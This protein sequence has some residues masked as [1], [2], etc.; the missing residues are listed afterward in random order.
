MPLHER[1]V[2]HW[3]LQL[4][5]HMRPRPKSDMNLYR[6]TCFRKSPM[7]S[8]V[9]FIF[10]FICFYAFYRGTC[11]FRDPCSAALTV[12]STLVS[13]SKIRGNYTQRGNF[14]IPSCSNS[15]MGPSMYELAAWLPRSKTDTALMRSLE[16]RVEPTVQWIYSFKNPQ[17]HGI[18]IA[19]LHDRK[20]QPLSG[21]WDSHR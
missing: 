19:A 2:S 14:Y 5:A 1:A 16:T 21:A 7:Q 4:F 8:T 20:I 9:S 3:L 6:S 18:L 12:F 17:N 15:M 10:V 11:P 13:R